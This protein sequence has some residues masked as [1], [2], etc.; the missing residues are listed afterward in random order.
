MDISAIPHRS[1]KRVVSHKTPLVRA[2]KFTKPSPPTPRPTPL[3]TID[4]PS[5]SYPPPKV[6]TPSL[7]LLPPPPP[8]MEVGALTGARMKEVKKK[9]KKATATTPY[10]TRQRVKKIKALEDKMQKQFEA[11]QKERLRLQSSFASQ[12]PRGGRLRTNMPEPVKRKRIS[13]SLPQSKRVNVGDVT[14]GELQRL[15]DEI[16]AGI[17]AGK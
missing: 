5:P 8:N 14:R 4:P 15:V 1:P 7:P 17:Q 3:I 11:T 12:T 9:K 10:S 13:A 6:A 16:D 2:S